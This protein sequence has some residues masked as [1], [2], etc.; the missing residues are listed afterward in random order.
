MKPVTRIEQ[1]ESNALRAH[2]ESAH[3][4]QRSPEKPSR[5]RGIDDRGTVQGVD[6]THLMLWK[7]T[8]RAFLLFAPPALDA[9]QQTIMSF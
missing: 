5:T 1:T 8:T 2:Q 9:L 3:S 4:N 7:R 6:R